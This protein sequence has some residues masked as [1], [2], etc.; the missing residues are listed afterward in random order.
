MTKSSASSLPAKPDPFDGGPALVSAEPDPELTALPAPPKRERT[1]AVILMI[2]TAL[3]AITMSVL[4]FGE[5]RYALAPS[6]PTEVG[7]LA[8]LKPTG[9]LENKYVL[10]SGLLG[11]TGA[12]RYARTAESDSFRLMPV[13]GNPAIWVEIRVPEGFEGPRFVPPNKFAG[14]L[15]PMSKAGMRHVGLAKSVKDQTEVTIPPDA[16]VL[17]DG[18][19]PRASRWAIALA[20]MFV[21]F[22]VWNLFGV[23]RVL[24]PVRDPSR[25]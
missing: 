18:A 4:L 22:A 24:R 11:A 2:L 20:A 7:E 21:A 6:S 23:A 3:A 25:S 17:V 1:A 12:I 9:D 13:A 5:A 10:A 19:S 14:R 15:V 16:W 8:T